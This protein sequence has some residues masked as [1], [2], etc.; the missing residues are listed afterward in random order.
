MERFLKVSFVL[1]LL[2]VGCGIARISEASIYNGDFSFSLDGW[3]SGAGIHVD[4]GWISR[5]AGYR[6]RTVLNSKGGGGRSS[7]QRV[8]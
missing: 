2:V 5:H 1:I 3:N 4:A 6:R 7:A 8:V